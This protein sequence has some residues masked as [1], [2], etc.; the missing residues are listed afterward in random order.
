MVHENGKWLMDDKDLEMEDKAYK[1]AIKVLKPVIHMYQEYGVYN[2][3]G[4][5]HMS[6]CWALYLLGSFIC[7]EM[8]IPESFNIKR[9]TYSDSTSPPPKMPCH[10]PKRK[11]KRGIKK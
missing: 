1:K 4:G 8:Q 3:E 9:L 7:Y 6:V 10:K 11:S 2:I 5:S